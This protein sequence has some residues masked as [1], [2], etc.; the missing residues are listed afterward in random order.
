MANI[1]PDRQPGHTHEDLVGLVSVLDMMYISDQ[2]SDF[3]EVRPMLTTWWKF[4][5]EPGALMR[6]CPS[7]L[8][9]SVISFVSEIIACRPMMVASR[10]L[11]MEPNLPS[12]SDFL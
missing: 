11:L 12:A 3:G 8:H 2:D 9:H 6:R 10:A 5:F 7:W 4:H 1:S